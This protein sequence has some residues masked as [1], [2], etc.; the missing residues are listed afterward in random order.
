MSAGVFAFTPKQV[1]AKSL[2]RL[3]VTYTMFF[4]GSR[5]GKTFL[6][7]WAVIT[8]ALIAPGSRHAILRLRFNHIKNT[9]ILDTFP[10][11][12][13][14]CYPNV[15]FHMD[16]SSWYAKFANGSEIWFGGLDD[17]ERSEK[18][19][20]MEFVTIYLNETSQISNDSKDMVVTRLAQKVDV[21]LAGKVVRPLEPKMFFDCNPPTKGHWTYKLFVKK[22]DPTTK[23]LLTEPDD[24]QFFQL[25]PRDNVENLSS[26]YIK[27]L[28]ALPPHKRKRFLDGEFGEETENG[29]FDDMLIDAYRVTNLD[30]LPEMVRVVVGVDPS[31]A[32]D[33]VDQSNDAIGIAAGG[34]GVDGF[35]Y[36]L[37]DATVQAG[38]ATWGKVVVQLYE[39]HEADMIVGEANFGG[40]MVEH[41]IQTCSDKP[42]PYK[43]VTA[44]RGKHVRADPI[45][46]LY[47]QGKIRHVG[48]YPD[49]E[50]ELINF[51]T[52]GYIGSDSPN[53]ADAVVWVFT[54][55]MAA[56]VNKANGKTESF[57]R[58]RHNG[59]SRWS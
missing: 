54:E 49:L 23:Q 18:I 5:S 31:G 35:G 32:S 7:C 38:P 48:Y 29:L 33:D 8:R 39:R 47:H 25:N 41:V 19:L 36:L 42:V 3:A 37:E 59:A 9:I 57:N 17:K 44:S 1:A 13:K 6:L 22:V 34:L 12:M 27:T 14:L 2:L 55:L 15:T 43:S 20:G 16:K 52:A 53:R 21:V 30:N 24:Y 51:T 40:A 58:N 56:I 50:D 11:V 10:K 4:G 28:E 46:V 26:K 45:S